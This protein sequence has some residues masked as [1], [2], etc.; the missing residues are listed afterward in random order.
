[1][2]EPGPRVAEWFGIVTDL[3]RQPLTAMPKRHLMGRLIE[4]FDVTGVSWNW[5]DDDCRFGLLVRPDNLLDPVADATDRWRSGELFD[6][7]ALLRWFAKT[8]DPRPWT[9]G[10]VPTQMV[11]KGSRAPHDELFGPIA[12]NQQLSIIYRLDGP[13]HR[14][15]VL[16]R[17]GRDFSDDDLVVARYVQ[18][19]VVALD[20]QT[21]LIAHLSA[22][23]QVPTGVEEAELTGRELSV[24][25]LL[26]EG[27][28]TRMIGRRLGCSPRTVEKHLENTYRKLGVRDRLN[29][30]R[31]ANLWGIVTPGQGSITRRTAASPHGSHRVPAAGTAPEVR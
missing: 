21:R 9:V 28:S 4:T 6:S 25:G 27:N 22:G 26:S 16:G 3:L 18:R 10:R 24:L 31:V 29:A 1:M 30:V 19:A 17:G 7:N 5:R 13:M 11:P 12:L 23:P 2:S 14:T 15:F 20:V 8:K